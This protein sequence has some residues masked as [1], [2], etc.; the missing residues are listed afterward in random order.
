MTLPGAGDELAYRLDE[1]EAD[2]RVLCERV[3][4]LMDAVA[5]TD[6]SGASSEQ[7][8]EEP[9]VPPS[10]FTSLEQWVTEWFAIVYARRTGGEARWCPCWW[11]H[12]EAIHRLEAL[13]AAWEAL[14]LDPKLG[15]GVWYRDHLDHQLPIL[16]SQRG[17]F[18]ACNVDRHSPPDPLPVRPAPPRWWDLPAGQPNPYRTDPGADSDGI[19][20]TGEEG[21][22]PE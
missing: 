1:H 11:A 12:A 22:E 7:L 4:T 21:S 3:D 20:E 6:G 13:W 18:A 14:R 2:L 17:P 9:A 5:L 15:M 19:T 8:E 10:G 16:T